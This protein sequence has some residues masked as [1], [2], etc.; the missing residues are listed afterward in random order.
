VRVHFCTQCNPELRV[1]FVSSDTKT[2]LHLLLFFFLIFF[3]SHVHA[4]LGSFLPVSPRPLPVPAPPSLTPP[5]TSLPG[6]N[7]F[8]LISNFVVERV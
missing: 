4:M 6:R 8:A 1:T 3:Y 5:Y 7:Y 2:S